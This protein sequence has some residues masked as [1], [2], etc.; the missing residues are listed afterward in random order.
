M[1]GGNRTEVAPARALGD[2]FPDCPSRTVS[3]KTAAEAPRRRHR[4]GA[5][6][7]VTQGSRQQRCEVTGTPH[8]RGD[9]RLW[10]SKD[11]FGFGHFPPSG[12]AVV[13]CVPM[14]SFHKLWDFGDRA[15]EAV[16]QQEG[17]GSKPLSS[18]VASVTS[19]LTLKLL[20]L[21]HLVVRKQKY[22][23]LLFITMFDILFF[24]LLCHGQIKNTLF[25][26]RTVNSFQV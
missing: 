23:C 15:D 2:A 4:A 24:V 19:L 18:A 1:V 3:V 8:C 16:G 11:R 12:K 9:A 25:G 17:T 21:C 14:K 20:W 26:N 5:G 13:M 10:D 6:A 22:S 7:G